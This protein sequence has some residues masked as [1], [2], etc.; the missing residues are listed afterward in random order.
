LNTALTD[1]VPVIP[2]TCATEQSTQ[3]NNNLNIR[4]YN[5]VN[6]NSRN[7][8]IVQGQD[9]HSYNTRSKEFKSFGPQNLLPTGD[10]LDLLTVFW[11]TGMSCCQQQENYI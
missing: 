3:I 7:N 9:Y 11:L 6:D 1:D 2:S 5:L 4:K 8:I 10:F